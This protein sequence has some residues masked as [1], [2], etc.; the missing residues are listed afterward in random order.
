M[1]PLRPRRSGMRRRT[2]DGN[3]HATCTTRQSRSIARSLRSFPLSPS[4]RRRASPFRERGSSGPDQ[5]SSFPC[6]GF[7]TAKVSL[8]N[9]CGCRGKVVVPALDEVHRHLHFRDLLE[10]VGSL[11]IPPAKGCRMVIGSI[12]AP[13]SEP[14][15]PRRPGESAGVHRCRRPDRLRPATLFVVAATSAQRPRYRQPKPK[16]PVGF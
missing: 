13:G 6:G 5:K 9:G 1:T 2:T 8:G 11:I 15:G 3:L 10:E 12:L 16:A 14:A 4:R 7:E